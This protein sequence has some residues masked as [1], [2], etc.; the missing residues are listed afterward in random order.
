MYLVVGEV[1]DAADETL[2]AL[3]C[4][5]E[6]LLNLLRLSLVVVLYALL[7]LFGDLVDFVI[8]LLDKAEVAVSLCG[9]G[10]G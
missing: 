3:I 8:Q 6:A 2:N 4:G 5:G 7:E 10:S 9:A 1:L